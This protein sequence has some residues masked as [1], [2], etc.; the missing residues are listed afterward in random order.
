MKDQSF[1]YVTCFLF[2]YPMSRA[3]KLDADS[4]VDEPA[5]LPRDHDHSC[6]RRDRDRAGS[7][8]HR[9]VRHHRYEPQGFT[10]PSPGSRL[11][12]EPRSHPPSEGVTDH[13][14]PRQIQTL[15]PSD[16]VPG[17]GFYLGVLAFRVVSELGGRA[18]DGEAHAH[19]MVDEPRAHLG[20]RRRVSVDKHHDG[21]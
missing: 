18:Q 19:E 3:W 14:E 20:E 12:C 11:L 8:L 1:R 6:V 5:S 17:T 9:D 10:A 16:T 13:P 2:S 21:T 4:V 15:R 7:R